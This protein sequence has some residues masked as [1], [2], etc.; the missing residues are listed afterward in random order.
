[1]KIRQITLSIVK[2]GGEVEEIESF[3]YRVCL[4]DLKGATIFLK[5]YD[6]SKITSELNSGDLTDISQVFEG[7]PVDEL[8]RPTT[9]EIDLLMGFEYAAYCPRYIQNVGNLVLMKNRFGKCVGGS[10]GCL[11]ADAS[12][13]VISAYINLVMT[14]GISDFVDLESLGVEC[15]PRCGSCRCG[16]CPIGGKELTL[17]EERELQLIE[18]GLFYENGR[19]IAHYPWK[20]NPQE[21]SDNYQMA[22]KEDSPKTEVM[23]KST[24]IK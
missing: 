14:K 10:S 6:I 17:R 18:S 20:R 11:K 2:V 13:V 19:W 12:K 16:K 23:L 15:T 5:A 9:G 1:M 7:V 3:E 8:K 4:D 21:L 24:P 22:L